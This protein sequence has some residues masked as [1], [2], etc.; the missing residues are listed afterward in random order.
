MALFMFDTVGVNNEL[1][2]HD[3]SFKAQTTNFSSEN[4]ENEENAADDL[5][6]SSE[7]D[8]DNDYDENDDITEFGGKAF[9]I[10][11]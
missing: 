9:I 2:E 10:N 3:D 5:Q 1:D 7:N 11:K 8:Q 4:S 6:S